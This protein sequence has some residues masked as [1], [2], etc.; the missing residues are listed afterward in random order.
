MTNC[1][2]AQRLQDVV[3]RGDQ[4]ELEILT[5]LKC[6]LLGCSPVSRVPV[7][8]WAAEPGQTISA[9]V[10]STVQ[11]M[12]TGQMVLWQARFMPK[13]IA[14]RGEPGEPAKQRKTT[15]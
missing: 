1:W 13:S 9:V 10:G 8:G 12:R 6:A 3:N 2:R 15:G 11:V 14:E 7:M 5:S 4:S